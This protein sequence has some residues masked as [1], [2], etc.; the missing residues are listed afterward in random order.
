[1]SRDAPLCY[2]EALY[3]KGCSYLR[4]TDIADHQSRDVTTPLLLLLS[5]MLAAAL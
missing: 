4:E 5:G 3:Q 1:M 2:R